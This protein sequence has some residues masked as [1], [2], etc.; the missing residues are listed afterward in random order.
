MSAVRRSVYLDSLRSIAIVAGIASHPAQAVGDV[1]RFAGGDI[2]GWMLSFFNQGGY[3][4]HVFF[5]LSGY[6]LAIALWLRESRYSPWEVNK[7]ILDQTA[8]QNISTVVD[9][10]CCCRSKAVGFSRI[11][12]RME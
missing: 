10:F 9:F 7:V 3:G 8:M 6:L 5:F 1:Q 12:W 11:S 4:G 2:D